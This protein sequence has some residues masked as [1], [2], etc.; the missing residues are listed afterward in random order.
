MDSYSNIVSLLGQ[1]VLW[2][3]IDSVDPCIFALF[4]SILTSSIMISVRNAIK[5]GI[6]YI[7]SIYIGYVIFGLLL[8]VTAIRLPI[9]VLVGI[10]LIYG[11]TMLFSSLR[12]RG[13][14]TSSEII[15]REDDIPCR[16]ANLLN[17]RKFVKGLAPVAFLGFISAFTLLPCSAGLYI[18]YNIVTTVYSY[19]IWVPLTLFYV[20]IFVLP[21]IA[22]MFTVVGLTSLGDV[23]RYLV[24][25][26]RIVKVVGSL[27]MISSG[28]YMIMLYR[29]RI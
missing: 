7:L 10:I 16:I 20:A 9:E 18:L 22:F 5:T 24:K 12:R 19:S 1:V 11:S 23:Y 21:L 15:C 3:L 2:A 29:V 17:F 25:H 8:R 6:T 14:S 28:I 4:L 26:E 13:V 27:I